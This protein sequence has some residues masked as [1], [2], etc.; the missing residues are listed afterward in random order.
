MMNALEK[1]VERLSSGTRVFIIRGAAGTGKTTLV[2]GLCPCLRQRGL[3]VALMA[4]TGRA[5]LILGKRTG[6][7][8]STIHSG[9]FSIG[10]GPVEDRNGNALKWI[11]PLKHGIDVENTAFI[12]DEASMVG[13][14]RH[15]N[16][17]ELLQFGSGSLLGDLV[18]YAGLRTPNTTNI[19]FFVGD[20]FQLPPVGERCERPP[21]LD[22]KVLRELTGFQPEVIELTEIHRQAA[23]SGILEE[24]TKMRKALDANDFNFFGISPHPDVR[25]V[26]VDE[27]VSRFKSGEN[28]DDKIVISFTNQKVG[29]YNCLLR[30]KLGHT[31]VLPEVGERLI[32]IRN[33]VVTLPTGGEFRFINGD[34]LNVIEVGD[35]IHELTGFYRPKDSDRTYEF[36]YCFCRMTLSWTYEPERKQACDIWVNVSPI[37]MHE[38]DETEEYASIGLYNGVKKLAEDKL[39]AAYPDF[40]RDRNRKAFWDALV[41]SEIGKSELLHAPVVRFG[42][43]VTG[44]KSQGGEWDY[45]FADYSTGSNAASSLYFRWAYTVTTRAR[46]CLSAACVP[47]LNSV[48]TVFAAQSPVATDCTE[49][50]SSFETLLKELG[51]VT[52]PATELS[53]RR[54]VPIA[55]TVGGMVVDG[56]VDVVYNGKSVVKSIEPHFPVDIE[57]LRTRLQI[58]VGKRLPDVFEAPLATR[59][60]L[61][62][63][64]EVDVRPEYR[65]VVDRMVDCLVS[66]DFGLLAVKA[67]PRN[68]YQIQF[69]FSTG[70][71][72]VYFNAKGR[73]TSCGKHTLP[74]KLWSEIS[75]RLRNL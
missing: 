67:L 52:S 33:T 17:R 46:K 35:E 50:V 28:M 63:G 30:A 49:D 41:R 31:N 34:F 4:P 26:P 48:A 42:Y 14:N 5:A 60:P 32:S 43:A 27:I 57:I 24:A 3:E 7:G 39:R 47:E 11:F 73:L 66:A 6:F 40:R 18:E 16:D 54:R 20:P 22:E 23:G 53:Y 37:T 59:T 72:D 15:E 10:D 8:A 2:R 74:E 71:F 70:V 58:F 56:H 1:I 9:I 38:W 68:P 61:P 36:K 69:T 64:V 65:A 25:I 51:Y 29:E 44:H 75:D 19:L 13:L 45:V 55:R 62:Q 21:A 12:V